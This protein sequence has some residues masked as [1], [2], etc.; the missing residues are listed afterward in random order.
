MA[1]YKNL[2]GGQ[3]A[4]AVCSGLEGPKENVWKLGSAQR[5][6]NFPYIPYMS[7]EVLPQS[8]PQEVRSCRRGL[9]VGAT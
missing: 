6:S 4:R 3:G 8:H 9:I 2:L 5:F 1:R 7:F